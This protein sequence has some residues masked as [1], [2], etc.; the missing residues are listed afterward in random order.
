MG[1][2]DWNKDVVKTYQL[3]KNDIRTLIANDMGVEESEIE[4]SYSITE[5]DRYG[6]YDL[7]SI[8]VKTKK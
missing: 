3:D 5:D 1:A 6:G 8:F 4:V 2:I 7:T